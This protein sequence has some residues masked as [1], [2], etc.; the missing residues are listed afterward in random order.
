MALHPQYSINQIPAMFEQLFPGLEGYQQLEAGNAAPFS[1]YP[2]YYVPGPAQNQNPPL[3]YRYGYDQYA[4]E[5]SRASYWTHMSSDVDDYPVPQTPDFLPIQYPV[6]SWESSDLPQITKKKSNELVG[7]GLYDNTERD[8]LSTFDCAQGQDSNHHLTFQRESMGKG[9]KL[10]E[11]WQPPK[12]DEGDDEDEDEASSSD[13]AEEDIPVSFTQ[14][15]TQ[16]VLYP[17]YGDLSNQTFFFDN[18]DPYTNCI[19]FDQ[20]MQAC[21]LKAPDPVGENSLWF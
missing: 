6:D 3:P 18:D 17:T 21:Q 5:E 20:T 16:P 19:A 8:V 10:E 12:E 4:S 7:M 13:E 15:Q 9:L 2:S 1:S 14:D 11:T